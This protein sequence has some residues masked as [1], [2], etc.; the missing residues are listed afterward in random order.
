MAESQA[1]PTPDQFAA[2][3]QWATQ[4]D[5]ASDPAPP[6]RWAVLELLG[7]RRLA[8]R[9]SEVEMFGVKMGRIDVPQG[10]RMVSQF[11]G[12]ASVYSMTFVSEE[13][14]RC[15]AKGL[16]VRPVE[17]WEM[18]KALPPAPERPS[19]PERYTYSDSEDDPDKLG[20]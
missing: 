20:F 12:G 11:F 13:A 8:G 4:A 16:E 7:H 3:L 2:P 5:N 19:E 14:A 15:V 1:K 17:P 6:E 18:P 10:E 9:V